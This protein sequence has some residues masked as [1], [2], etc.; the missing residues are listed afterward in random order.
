MAVSHSDQ[1]GGIAEAHNCRYQIRPARSVAQ[2]L[3]YTL[4]KSGLV[5]PSRYCLQGDMTPEAKGFGTNAEARVRSNCLARLLICPL[6]WR[7]LSKNPWLPIWM[8]V[9]ALVAGTR[10]RKGERQRLNGALLSPPEKKTAS[11]SK[12]YHPTSCVTSH[13]DRA[14]ILRSTSR[15]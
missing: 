6:V 7:I 3:A 14:I 11:K 10:K 1:P 8:A 12:C 4:F 9:P 5:S 2:V 15:Y 13:T